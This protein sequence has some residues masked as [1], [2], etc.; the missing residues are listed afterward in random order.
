MNKEEALALG[1]PEERLRDFQEVYNRDIRRAVR[2]QQAG[3][4][5]AVRAAIDSMLPLIHSVAALREI[6]EV[7]TRLYCLSHTKPKED[8]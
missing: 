5:K 6:L 8:K 3:S 4:A 1:V 2:N 7:V